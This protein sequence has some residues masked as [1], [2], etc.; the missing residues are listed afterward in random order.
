MRFISLNSLPLGFEFPP[1]LCMQ[2]E[3]GIK[4]NTRLKKKKTLPH[5][6]I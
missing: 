1:T 4:Q 6:E 3:K 2:K 5:L